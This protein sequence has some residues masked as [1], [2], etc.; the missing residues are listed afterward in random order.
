[1]IRSGIRHLLDGG[2]LLIYPSGTIDP[3]PSIMPGARAE[4]VKWSRSL[5]IFLRRAPQTK[6]LVTIVSGVLAAECIRHPITWLRKQRKDR[7][8]L[9]EMLQIIQQLVLDKKFNLQPRL[10]FGE[11]IS[12]QQYPGKQLMPAIVETADHTLINHLAW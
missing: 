11:T 4:L 9:A 5:E 10:T 8:R 6:V 1:V 7:Q 2:A 3:D 12:Y